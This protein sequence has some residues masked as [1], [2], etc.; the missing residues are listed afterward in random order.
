MVSLFSK[1]G[2]FFFS[3][4][5]ADRLSRESKISAVYSSDLKRACETAKTIAACCGG[6]EVST[7]MLIFL[8]SEFCRTSNMY[9]M[10]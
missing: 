7:W 4:K 1:I 3:F 9:I 6:V 2:I 5:V 10:K 8:K